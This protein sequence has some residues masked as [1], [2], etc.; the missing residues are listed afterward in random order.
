MF[1]TDIESALKEIDLNV[2]Y[3]LVDP[4]RNEEKWDY[5]VF[6]RSVIKRNTNKTSASDYFDVHIVRENYVP[7]GMDNT[8]IEKLC[9][10]PGIKLT[11]DDSEFDYTHKPGT[12]N[13]VEML[14]IHFARARK[15]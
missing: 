2:D 8:V 4:K 11:G 7:D 14:T 13:V 3:G 10:L 15:N 9:A 12:N 5:I 6:N 1:L